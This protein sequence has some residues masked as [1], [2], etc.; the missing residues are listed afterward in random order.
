M[1]SAWIFQAEGGMAGTLREHV[2]RKFV[3]QCSTSGTGVRPQTPGKS[4]LQKYLVHIAPA[5]VFTGLEGS[6]DGMFGLAEVFR[7][8]FVL[9]GITATHVSAD[10][11]LP[12]MDPGVA[13]FQALF[14]A[15]AG[16]FSFSYF[17]QV[18]TGCSRARHSGFLRKN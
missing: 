7:G 10:Q 9:G 3:S 2:H 6:D 5:P 16:R 1:P 14:A 4:D 18:G 13:H 11:A 8:M 12:Q 17:S 15:L